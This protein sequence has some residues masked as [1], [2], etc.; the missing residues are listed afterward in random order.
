MII[1]E[2]RSHDLPELQRV[3]DETGLFPSDLLPDLIG[4]FLRDEPC[5]DFWLTCESGGKLVG[6]CYA[7][8]EELA[9]GTWNMRA[10]AVLPEMQGKGSGAT[11]VAEIESRLRKRGERILIAETS[12]TAEYEQTR[13]FYRKNGYSEEARIRDFW[14]PD[15]DKV[16]FWKSLSET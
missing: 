8:A 7:A 15:D 3:L 4:A 5:S 1:R 16:V 6:F 12:A 9:E 14:G 13:D 10:I 2:T 11:L